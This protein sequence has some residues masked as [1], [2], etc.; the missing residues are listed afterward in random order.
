M[1]T[2]KPKHVYLMANGDLRTLAN[3]KCWPEQAKME[4][5]LTKALQS[6]GWKVVRA[7]PYVPGVRIADQNTA[8]VGAYHTADIPYFLGTQDAYNMFR[9]T[10]NW[11]P[12]DRE[13]SARMM[14]SL[15]A[16]AATG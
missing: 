7:H 11:T 6:E 10:R 13:M 12:W 5:V 15:I 1:A 8:T 16:M 4:A 9:P 3:Q 14:G 2:L